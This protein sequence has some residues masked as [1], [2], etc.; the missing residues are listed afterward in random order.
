MCFNVIWMSIKVI[1]I[2]ELS[3]VAKN[4]AESSRERKGE[5]HRQVTNTI[6][7]FMI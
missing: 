7:T 6:C 2:T 4:Y 1:F 5:S 3:N